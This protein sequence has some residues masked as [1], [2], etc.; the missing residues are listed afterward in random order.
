MPNVAGRRAAIPPALVL[1]LSLTACTLGNEADPIGLTSLEDPIFLVQTEA[2]AAVMEA[3][4]DGPIAA[5][6]AGCVR[7]QPSGATVVWPFGFSLREVGGQH[8]VI[9]GSNRS[10]GRIGGDFRFGGGFVPT[11]HEGIPLDQSARALAED[12]CPGS[13]WIVGDVS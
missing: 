12:R 3:L 2:A 4:F 10:I 7:L 11:L 5:D 6:D 9:D 1:A 8:Y 13:Y